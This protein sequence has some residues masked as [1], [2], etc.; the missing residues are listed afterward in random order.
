MLT[1]VFT[2]VC[3]TST[4]HTY[5]TTS[6]LDLK[7]HQT[8]E[9]AMGKWPSFNNTS[10]MYILGLFLKQQ[11]PVLKT[12][13]ERAMFMLAILLSQQKNITLNGKQFA[14]RLEETNG[15][16]EIDTLDRTCRSISENQ[17]LGIVGPAGSNEA[18]TIA[19]FCNRAGLPVIGY[20]TTD[21]ELSDR[22]A[23]R[24]FYRM[25]ASDNITAQSLL[26]LFK[27]YK[28]NSTN[29]IYQGDN[30]G[31]GGLQALT[32]TF[33][34]ELKISRRI[35][36]DIFTDQIKDFR[37]QLEKSPSRIVILWANSNITK[38]II[39]L[40]IKEGGILAPHFLWIFTATNSRMQLKDPQ[41][42]GMLLI[43]PVSPQ[44]FS[45]PINKT[46]LKEAT[47]IWKT[48]DPQSY[49]D[50]EEHIDVYALYAFDSAWM[51]ILAFTE[52]CKQ[53][54]SDCFSLVNTSHCFASR[55]ANQNKL[56]NI[57]QTIHFIGVSGYVQFRKNT[58]DRLMRDGSYFII[59]NLQPTKSYL[60]ELHT[61]EVLKLSDRPNGATYSSETQWIESGHAILWPK[62][63]GTV[64]VDYAELEG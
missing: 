6:D 2:L 24:T 52:F 41:L 4:K 10:Y 63:F 49:H 35:K 29:I 36:Y 16:D 5:E 48:Y 51:L 30:Y 8:E 57:M 39:Q 33:G 31:Q 58:T 56:H 15:R 64:P 40:A 11:T 19:R 21:P 28:W 47:D 12:P 44:I 45:I 9:G 20:S 34:S 61:V 55:L 7:N 54:P 59:D 42:A 50:D 53:S 23:Y 37:L 3:Q 62:G 13:E 25:S 43:R 38:K 17:I 26:K 1:I 27:K 22:N 46:L 32:E 60:D 18:K 14:Y